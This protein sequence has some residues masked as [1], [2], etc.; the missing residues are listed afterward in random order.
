MNTTKNSYVVREINPSGNLGR[1]YGGGFFFSEEYP[2]A[3]V[4]NNERAARKHIGMLLVK[5]SCYRV[6]IVENPGMENERLIS[7]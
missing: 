2:E 5:S 4:F 6:C 3:L 1:F 7:L